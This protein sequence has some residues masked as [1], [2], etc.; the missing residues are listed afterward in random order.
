VIGHFHRLAAATVVP[1]SRVRR[2][3]TDRRRREAVGGDA[4]IV[5]RTES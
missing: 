2:R 3:P 1:F 5:Y 4:E